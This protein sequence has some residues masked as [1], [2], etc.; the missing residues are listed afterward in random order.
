MTGL[1]KQTHQVPAV[2]YTKMFVHRLQN[3]ILGLSNGKIPDAS[4]NLSLLVV[5]EFW[6]A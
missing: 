3:K 6:V 1:F 2:V 4:I 5:P